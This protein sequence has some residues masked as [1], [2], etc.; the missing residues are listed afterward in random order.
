MLLDRLPERARLVVNVVTTLFSLFI[1]ALLAWQGW[2][3]GMEE[4]AVSDML[5]IP[6]M[7]FK[8]LVAVAGSLLCLELLVDLFEALKALQRRA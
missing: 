4:K 3:V 6:Q 5:R 1:M 7:P 2:V 8:L